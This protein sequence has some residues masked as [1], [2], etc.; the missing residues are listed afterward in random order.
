MY[1]E[2]RRSDETITELGDAA[3]VSNQLDMTVVFNGDVHPVHSTALSVWA[4]SG[5]GWLLIAVQST[6]I[7]ETTQKGDKPSSS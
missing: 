4:K 2:V 1:R 3:L 5:G 6:A 7:P